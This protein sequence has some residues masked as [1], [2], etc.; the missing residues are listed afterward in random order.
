[1]LWLDLWSGGEIGT[2]LRGF[3]CSLLCTIMQC[4]GQPDKVICTTLRL[5]LSFLKG[6]MNN[7]RKSDL[8]S[9]SEK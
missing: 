3:V 5:G 9:R 8:S 1:M 4:Y 7:G 2:F 6:R